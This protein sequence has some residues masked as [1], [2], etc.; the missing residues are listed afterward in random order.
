MSFRD[1]TPFSGGMPTFRKSHISM[2]YPRPVT[3]VHQCLFDPVQCVSTFQPTPTCVFELAS[4][5]HVY[6][7]LAY[8]FLVLEEEARG[9]AVVHDLS[10]EGQIAN[11]FE[12]G[13]EPVEVISTKLET[14]EVIL[15]VPWAFSLIMVRDCVTGLGY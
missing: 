8:F 6:F 3:Q 5:P 9:L 14:L 4:F 15:G 13:L 11:M 10:S 7:N 1:I 2:T 12:C